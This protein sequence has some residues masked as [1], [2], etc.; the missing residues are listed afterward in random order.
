MEA[1]NAIDFN[2]QDGNLLATGSNDHTVAIWDIRNMVIK[3]Y[4]LEFHKDEVFN[5]RFAPFSSTLLA[6]SSCDRTV[7][8][9]DLTKIGDSNGII[10][11]EEGPSELLYVHGGHCANV[12]DIS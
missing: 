7:L 9:W 12:S 1:I 5:V 10:S 8:L 11:E 3:L 6:S 2:K 4:T